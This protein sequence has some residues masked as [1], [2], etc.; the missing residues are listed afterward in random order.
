MPE[1]RKDMQ[2]GGAGGRSNIVE[3]LRRADAELRQEHLGPEAEARIRTLV[4]QRPRVMVLRWGGWAAGVAVAAAMLLWVLVPREQPDPAPRVVAGFHVVGGVARLSGPRAGGPPPE[5]GPSAPVR[6]CPRAGVVEC[7]SRAC[8]LEARDLSTRL[9]LEDDTI[10]GRRRG[11]LF[12]FRGRVT[13][14]VARRPRG[15][16]PL[17]VYVSEGH[18]EVLGTIFSLRQDAGGRGEVS[19][20]QGAIR[21]VASDGRV[22]RLEPGQRLT[23]PLPEE[24]GPRAPA[25]QPASQP[26]PR[27]L[28]PREV[29][30]L[31]ERVGRL[32]NQGRFREATRTL[33]RALGRIADRATRESFSYELGAI[34]THHL[35]DAAAACRHWRR[36]LRR[37]GSSRYGEEIRQARTR[38]GCP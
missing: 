29:E 1:A 4:E 31:E 8:V 14:R 19:L 5:C 6:H 11:Q 23:W 20:R 33:R 34:L 3:A 13:C 32:R 28:S 25:S 18:I 38:L 36:H 27:R 30:T 2:S 15:A 35:P 10:V 17:R 24:K 21:F 12:L 7:G 26:S 37:F 16:P 9:E 22:M